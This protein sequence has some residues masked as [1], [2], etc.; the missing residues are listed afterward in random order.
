MSRVVVL[1]GEGPLRSEH[2]SFAGAPR[3]EGGRLREARRSFERDY[4]VRALSRNGGNR[5]RTA[6]DLGLTRQALLSKIKRLG[7]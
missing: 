2:L 4:V 5:A 1:A 3:P 7:I 6:S